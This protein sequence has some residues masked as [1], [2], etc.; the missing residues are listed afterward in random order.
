MYV[1]LIFP[2]EIVQDIGDALGVVTEDTKRSVALS[3]QN[4]A[5]SAGFM[6]VV[7]SMTPGAPGDSPANVARTR[8][9]S[10]KGF[11][12]IHRH[13]IP[14]PKLVLTIPLSSIVFCPLLVNTHAAAWAGILSTP[15]GVLLPSICLTTVV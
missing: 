1:G 14:A 12:V 5:D 6:T 4:A 8:S 15:L 9:P 13:S 7:N 3:T 10:V 11:S 2:T